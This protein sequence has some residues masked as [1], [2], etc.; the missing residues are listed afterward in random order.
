[1]L[2]TSNRN[3]RKINFIP[4]IFIGFLMV[5]SFIFGLLLGSGNLGNIRQ[6]GP[7]QIKPAILNQDSG[8]PQNI[9]FKLFWDA[10]N[11][12]ENKYVGSLDYQKMLYGAVKG[13][14]DSLEDPYTIYLNPEESKQFQEEI[15]GSF[16]GVG[17]E[18][19]IKNGELVVI[20]ALPGTPADKAGLRSKDKIIKINGE[21]TQIMTIDQATEK[22]KGPKDTEVTLTIQRGKDAP[23]DYK[24]KR[25]TINVNSVKTEYE[26][27]GNSKIAII[28]ITR[29]EQTTPDS[30]NKAVEDIL[31]NQPKGIILDLRGNPGGYFTGAVDIASEFLD[32]GIVVIEESKNG[33][34]KS[35]KTS[36]K[37]RLTKN[38]LIVLID[39]GSASASEIVAGAIKD[40]NRGKI[41]GQKS[42]G[43]G[44][45][46]QVFDLDKGFLKITISKW[47]TPS[48]K[49]INKAGIEPD[50]KKELTEADYNNGKDPQLDE[51]LK[52]L[53]E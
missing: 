45:V 13:M 2:I 49:S 25:D 38:P 7:I 30:F 24:L 52:I 9:D 34:R 19:G 26:K 8:K 18:I 3:R 53:G 41:L 50:I 11:M 14:T 51:A 46:Q 17:M 20:S 32:G 31:M 4:I 43:K 39:E 29:F 35:F 5:G 15:D 22:I 40:R 33:N 6:I 42:F 21:E 28:K 10:W 23:K 1:M 44:L 12:L 48:G 47:L 16:S 37:G 27:V 36:K